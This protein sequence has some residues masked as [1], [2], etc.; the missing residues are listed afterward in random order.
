M[1]IGKS[2]TAV[3]NAQN[4]SAIMVLGSQPEHN[5]DSHKIY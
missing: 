4:I 5:V 1:V 3:Y 2:T